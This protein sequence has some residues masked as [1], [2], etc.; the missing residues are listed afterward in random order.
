[1]SPLVR[2]PPRVTQQDSCTPYPMGLG[3]PQPS[4]LARETEAQGSGRKRRS[5]VVTV[6]PGTWPGP[7]DP[8]VRRAVPAHPQGPRGESRSRLIWGVCWDSRTGPSSSPPPGPCTSAQPPAAEGASPRAQA[9]MAS[10]TRG[11]PGADKT[12]PPSPG[13]LLHCPGTHPLLHQTF[14]EGWPGAR[15]G[16]A[17]GLQASVWRGHCPAR[18]GNT[19]LQ[20][21]SRG[22]WQRHHPLG[23]QERGK[24]VL[25]GC[26][27][28]DPGLPGA[29]RVS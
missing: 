5:P 24:S 10:D 17:P 21:M 12:G 18:K 29:P 26:L 6:W 20:Q 8:E 15:P 16:P 11:R 27:A 22:R 19:E 7:L 25:S 28:H 1:M 23:P 14:T 9:G 13:P 3:P 4:F 2:A